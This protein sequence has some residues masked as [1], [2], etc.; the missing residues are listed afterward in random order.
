[1]SITSMSKPRLRTHYYVWCEPPDQS[2]NETLYFASGSKRIKIKGHSFREFRDSVIPLLDGGHTVEEIEEKVTHLFAANDLRQCLNLLATQSLLEDASLPSTF[3][4][5]DDCPIPQL[6]FLHEVGADVAQVRDR[7][8]QATVAIFGL[9]GAGAQTALTLAAARIGRLRCIDHLSV[10]ATDMYFSSVFS[11]SQLNTPRASAVA[12]AIRA[13]T[14]RT[15]T[16]V[17]TQVLNC[18][19]DVEAVIEGSDFVICCV[20]RGQSSV[21]YK[22]NRACLK[23]NIRW[24]SG[25]LR[26]T[27]VILGPTIHPAETACFLCYKMR[28]V[29]CAGN[30][31]DEFAYERFLDRRK[32]DDS[33]R[34]ENIVFGANILA[35]LLGMETLKEVSA[36]TEPAAVGKL[37]VLDLLSF[38]TAKHLI[39]RK[40]WCPACVDTADELRGVTA[41]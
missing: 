38:S 36:F 6:N 19:S 11:P 3:D 1:M 4:V 15:N 21:A 26:G 33:S 10:D 17:H 22:I 25:A 8:S 9:G 34:H 7:L 2:G 40:P 31:E 28:A 14:P 18:D 37:V 20:D 41:P 39:L 24:T 16:T 5:S 29:A 30:P 23:R 13:R 35:G 32:Q 27:E 12:D